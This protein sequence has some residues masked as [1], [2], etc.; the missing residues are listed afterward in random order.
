[1]YMENF[2]LAELAPVF[3]GFPTVPGDD[4]VISYVH[5]CWGGNEEQPMISIGA[6]YGDLV[7]GVL[8]DPAKYNGR[9]IQGISESRSAE[10][11]AKDFQDGKNRGP[12]QI[13]G[14][15][16]ASSYRQED[17]FRYSRERGGVSDFRGQGAGHRQGHL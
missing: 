17:S 11:I 13:L 14:S 9:L 10:A 3:G 16:T 1:M 12:E 8:L 4:G 15:L 5:P 2:L 6:D 7:H